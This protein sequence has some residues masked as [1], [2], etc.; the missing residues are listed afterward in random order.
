MDLQRMRVQKA[1]CGLLAF[2]V[3]SLAVIV[4]PDVR[5]LAPNVS[6]KRPLF[7]SPSLT[8]C[9]PLQLLLCAVTAYMRQGVV[10]V[11]PGVRTA[12]EHTALQPYDLGRSRWILML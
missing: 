11:G 8:I 1:V 7:A 3:G 4:S 2:N 12:R 9:G 5:L 10:R 6:R